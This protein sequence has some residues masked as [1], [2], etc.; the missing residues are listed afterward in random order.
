[1][2][3]NNFPNKLP[4]FIFQWDLNRLLTH[5]VLAH[6]RHCPSI[7]FQCNRWRKWP[8]NVVSFV[9]PYLWVY[10]IVLRFNISIWCRI[11]NS[12]ILVW[13]KHRKVHDLKCEA[14][15][16]TTK[17]FYAIEL[18]N[19]SEEPIFL[20]T[21]CHPSQEATT[22]LHFNNIYFAV[23]ELSKSMKH[24]NSCVCVLYLKIILVRFIPL[25]RMF[26]VSFELLHSIGVMMLQCIYPFA[27]EHLEC[28]QNAAVINISISIISQVF[29]NVLCI[30]WCVCDDSVSSYW[31]VWLLSVYLIHGVACTGLLLS[32]PTGGLIFFNLLRTF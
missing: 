5:H 24:T 21:H 10:L 23:F 15:Q 28:F 9:L 6:I 2:L 17:G 22:S 13:N 4:K 25:L 7:C 20:P 32:S 14:K 16:M 27:V 30:F 3:L 19:I 18:Y 26:Y 11:L 1:M 31:S 8:V 12:L 29:F